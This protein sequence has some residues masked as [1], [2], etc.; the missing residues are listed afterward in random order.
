MASSHV[1]GIGE[2]VPEAD[3]VYNEESWTDIESPTVEAYTKSKAAAEKAAW[4]YVKE[5]P[6]TILVAYYITVQ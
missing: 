2:V 6:G 5:L 4:D 3:K 1:L